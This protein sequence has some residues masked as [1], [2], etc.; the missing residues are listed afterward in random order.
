MLL[1]YYHICLTFHAPQRR[2]C[3]FISVIRCRDSHNCKVPADASRYKTLIVGLEGLLILTPST[4]TSTLVKQCILEQCILVIEE[5]LQKP[6]HFAYNLYHGMRNVKQWMLL[7]HYHTS[8]TTFQSP[9]QRLAY[10]LYLSHQVSYF[11]QASKIP[12]WRASRHNK[13]VNRLPC[14]G[15]LTTVKLSLPFYTFQRQFGKTARLPSAKIIIIISENHHH[16]HRKSS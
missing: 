5:L 10:I 8:S 6:S 9:L 4:E 7:F 1:F 16:H 11:P 12:T 3:E 13:E 2:F 14:D 15:K